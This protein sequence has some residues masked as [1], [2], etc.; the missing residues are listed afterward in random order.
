MHWEQ[1]LACLI[2]KAACALANVLSEWSYNFS[3]TV[4]VYSA[5]SSGLAEVGSHGVSSAY[6]IHVWGHF[7]KADHFIT[8][9]GARGQCAREHS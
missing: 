5:I 9:A 2:W 3:N 8:I 1:E 4:Q 6:H 7:A